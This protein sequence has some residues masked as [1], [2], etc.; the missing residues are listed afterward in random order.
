MRHVNCQVRLEIARKT[1]NMRRLD[2]EV[3]LLLD[4]PCKFLH[5][6]HGIRNLQFL[7]M[8][9]DKSGNVEHYLQIHLNNSVN[10]RTPNL[11]CYFFAIGQYRFIDLCNGSGSDGRISQ[12]PEN[13]VN[14][15]AQFLFDDPFSIFRRKWWYIL[16]KFFQFDDKLLWYHIRPGAHNLTEF[17]ECWSQLLQ[18]HSHPFPM[19][20]SRYLRGSFA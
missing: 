11:D 19:R 13:A 6:S 14:R 9:L 15:T 8:S 18:S 10:I 16:L 4:Y 3:L 7:E 5:Y 2:S 17:D 20:E 12:I 1:L